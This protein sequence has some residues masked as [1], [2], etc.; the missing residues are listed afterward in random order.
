[1]LQMKGAKKEGGR[2]QILD[3]VRI[4]AALSVVLYHYLY[5][6]WVSGGLSDVDFGQYNGTFKYGYLGV[7]LFF[8]ISG[9]LVTMSSEGRSCGQFFLGRVARL[10]PAYWFCLLVTALFI[11]LL[12]DGRFYISALDM[13]AN[14]TMISKLFGVPFVDGAYWTLIYE[15]VFYFWIFVLLLTK[16][17]SLLKLL[18]WLLLFSSIGFALDYSGYVSILYGGAFICYFALGVCFYE[19]YK[20]DRSFLLFSIFIVSVALMAIQT[21]DQAVRKNANIGSDLDPLVCLFIV[22]GFVAFFALLSLGLFDRFRFRYAA[23]LGGLSYPCYLLHQNVGYIIFNRFN[24][25]ID[26]ASLLVVVLLFVLALSYVVFKFIEPF[27]VNRIMLL[28]RKVL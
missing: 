21:V 17:C 26:D 18:G 12:D 11:Y 10:Y 7:Q 8:I 13:L 19:Y 6:G 27:L 2:L 15:L 28:G 16:A 23:L 14:L 3:L 9:F 25:V 20:G 5:R 22:G 4:F 1:M 24:G